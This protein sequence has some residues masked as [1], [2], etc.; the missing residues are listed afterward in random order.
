MSKRLTL[1][2]MIVLVLL[3]SLTLTAC[4]KE[5]PLVTP[6]SR[7]TVAPARATV[8]PTQPSAVLTQTAPAQ[9]GTGGQATPP[10]AGATV[11][12]PT[13]QPGAVNPAPT[14]SA[15]GVAAP[16][17]TG[18][19]TVQA[20]DTL[21]AIARRF[22]TTIAELQRLNNI[23]NPDLLALGQTLIVPGGSENASPSTTTTGDGETY[24][25]QAGDT[26]GKI[27]AEFGVT[28]Q[29]LQK[30]NNIS[31]PD[32]ISVGQELIIP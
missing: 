4:E 10:A 6:A 3:L 29:D 31:D 8:G 21:A 12:A 32:L 15:T 13:A 16:S 9:S 19:Y 14:G 27:A 23:T 26:L 7:A 17:G 24:T 2:V 5:R 25:V 18:T 28:V 30:A 22:D 11:T 1:F 20:G